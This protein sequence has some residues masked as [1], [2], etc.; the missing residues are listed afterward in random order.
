MKW[1]ISFLSVHT[2]NRI[3]RIT[4]ICVA[5]TCDG[6]LAMQEGFNIVMVK[7]EVVLDLY[8]QNA[9]VYAIIYHNLGCM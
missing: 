5:V 8:Y 4:Q 6:G 7:L 9:L 3:A 1:I 2:E